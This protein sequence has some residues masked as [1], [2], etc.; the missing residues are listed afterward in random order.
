MSPTPPGDVTI[1]LDEIRNG[2]PGALSLL[3]ERIY[4]ELRRMADELMNRERPDHSLQATALVHEALLRLFGSQVFGEAPNRAYLFGAAARA[5]QEVLTEHARRRSAAKR[6]G[7]RQRVPLDDVLDSL[8]AQHVN[9]IELTEAVDRL[10][11]HN[12]RQAQVV[13]LRF[14]VGLAVPEVAEVLGV[15]VS[16]VEND[17]RFA[18]AW[19]RRKLASQ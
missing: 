19:L 9:V 8:H 7:D 2:D 3:V 6:G 11:V 1:L 4:A 16:T 17:W 5:M 14:F 18:R 15:S 12:P 10:A 13:S